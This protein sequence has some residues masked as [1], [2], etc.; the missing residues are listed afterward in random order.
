MRSWFKILVKSLR[1]LSASFSGLFISAAFNRRS[2][3]DPSVWVWDE[4]GHIASAG[5]HMGRVRHMAPITQAN[6]TPA[7]TAP[8][9]FFTSLSSP[10]P[11]PPLIP[12][13][14]FTTWGNLWPH[15]ACRLPLGN[16]EGDGWWKLIMWLRRG[17][18]VIMKAGL[19]RPVEVSRWSGG[20]IW[21]LDEWVSVATAAFMASSCWPGFWGQLLGGWVPW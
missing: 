5:G 7:P 17:F 1:R 21:R 16:K 12:T 20:S 4:N 15:I 2:K 3:V 6:T 19:W 13:A 10:P 8:L 9:F 14:A 11:L 18:I